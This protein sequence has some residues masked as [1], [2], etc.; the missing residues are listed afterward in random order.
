VLLVM[1]E[2]GLRHMLSDKFK[3]GADAA[4]ATGPVGRDTK[5]DTDIL[6]NAWR[7]GDRSTNPF[8]ESQPARC[9]ADLHCRFRVTPC[10]QNN[11]EV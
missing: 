9:G 7:C 2:K 4:A 6:M 5:A 11:I 8:R 3:I 1:D 10:S